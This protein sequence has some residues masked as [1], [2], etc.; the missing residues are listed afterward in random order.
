MREVGHWHNLPG[1]SDMHCTLYRAD[2]ATYVGDPAEAGESTRIEWVPVSDLR[3]R[4]DDDQI[5]DGDTLVALAL[6]GTIRPVEH[7][8]RS[9]DATALPAPDGRQGRPAVDAVDGA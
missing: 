1:I 9:P 8:V 7:L 6:A 2:G 3:Q 5:T 4:I